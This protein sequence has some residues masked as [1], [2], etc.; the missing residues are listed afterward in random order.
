L[1][2]DP[3]PWGDVDTFEDAPP[4]PI[5]IQHCAWYWCAK[6]YSDI[7][8]TPGG[9]VERV[10]GEEKLYLI[11]QKSIPSP[12]SNQSD[13]QHYLANSTGHNYTVGYLADKYM[14]EM[15]LNFLKSTF[16]QRTAITNNVSLDI[17]TYLLTSNIT[18]A[19]GNIAKT[20]T[21]QMRSED[22]DN[23]DAT[24]ITGETYINRVFITVRWPW[25][26]LPLLETI[27]TAGLLVAA[28]VVSH[29]RPLWKNSLIALLIHGLEGYTNYEVV[30]QG[31]ESEGGLNRL[32]KGMTVMLGKD[33][34][35]RLKLLRQ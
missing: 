8:G 31:Q 5:E 18:Q 22:L 35:A 34:N 12:E 6:N 7:L 15:I 27:F 20:I 23:L 33:E 16:I 13:I 17:G 25:L 1:K 4:P 21:A 9:I 29:G 14:L 2:S 28:I 24:F 11:G 19:A 32:A 3:N 26:L 30:V 10:E